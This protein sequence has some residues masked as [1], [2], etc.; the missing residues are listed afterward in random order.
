MANPKIKFK[1]SAVEGKRPDN[2]SLELGEIAVNTY[3]GRIYLKRD[4]SGADIDG[5]KL[6]NPWIENNANTGIA[7]TYP[8][9]IS[10]LT[11]FTQNVH[12]LDSDKLLFGAGEDLEIYHDGSH[13]YI[14]DQGQG[15]LK[16]LSNNIRF[17]N[18]DESKVSATFVASG[19]VDLYYDN[20]LRFSTTGVGVTIWGETETRT[21]NVS[22]VS[23]FGSNIISSGIITATQFI[24][25]GSGL[26][27]IV[28]TG[29]GVYIQ[30]NDTQ[31]GAASTLAFS[32]NLS[33]TC[34]LYTSDAAD[35]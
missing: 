22:G 33:A 25:D 26:S 15:N 10:G 6:V 9:N 18:P 34:L 31:I 17:T 14:S 16:V 27:N 1:R 4:T 28:G 20:N 23:T 32:G 2:S 13:S 21:L 8:I 35:E 29:T 19:D 11:T 30:V 12:L 3:D 5:I 7:C 24:G